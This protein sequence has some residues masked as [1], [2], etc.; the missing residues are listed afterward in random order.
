MAAGS[1]LGPGAHVGKLVVTCRCPVVYSTVC[2]TT[3]K[4]NFVCHE[5]NVE[6]I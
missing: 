6:N 5:E 2:K 4:S 1:N 3:N